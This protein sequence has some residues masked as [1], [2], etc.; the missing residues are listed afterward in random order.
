[1]TFRNKCTELPVMGTFWC[2]PQWMV[3]SETKLIYIV[4]CYV[5]DIINYEFNMF[6][7]M[8]LIHMRENKS[9]FGFVAQPTM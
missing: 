8:T 9:G 4:F 6:F 1:M 3:F 2:I 7:N 5:D